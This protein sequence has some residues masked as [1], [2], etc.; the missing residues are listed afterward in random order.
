MILTLGVNS[1]LLERDISTGIITRD[2]PILAE[3]SPIHNRSSASS[4]PSESTFQGGAYQKH[5]P[6]QIFMGKKEGRKNAINLDNL[7][8]FCQIRVRAFICVRLVGGLQK[9][10]CWAGCWS[11]AAQKSLRSDHGGRKRARNH[12]TAEIARFSQKNR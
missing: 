12:S 2:K 3:N 6:S 4:C 5:V 8:N 10:L 7:G 1:L 9:Y 11:R